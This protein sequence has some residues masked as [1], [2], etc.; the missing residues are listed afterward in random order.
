M[1]AAAPSPTAGAT[2]FTDP[3]RTSPAAKTPGVLVSCGR[4]AR[5]RGHWTISE[6]VTRNP[7]ESRSTVSASQSECGSAP[8]S[9][10]SPSAG[11][12]HTRPVLESCSE[13]VSRRPRPSTRVITVLSQTLMLDARSS[14]SIKYADIRPDSDGPRTSSV[15]CELK[16]G[17]V[18]RR[19]R[20]A[21]SR[22]LMPRGNPR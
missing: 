2:R 19:A 18:Y 7:R 10:K 20:E 5:S 21:S 8:M 11:S 16:R 22:P 6:P 12:V 4:G 9:T 17:Q 3:C 15:T 13:M 1:M 14:S